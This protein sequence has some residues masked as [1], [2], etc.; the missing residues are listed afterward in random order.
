MSPLE[1][2]SLEPCSMYR[3]NYVVLVGFLFHEVLLSFTFVFPSRRNSGN[4]FHFDS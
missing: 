4:D 2:V 1:K 3:N